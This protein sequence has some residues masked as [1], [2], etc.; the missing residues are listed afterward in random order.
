MM[1][2]LVAFSLPNVKTQPH[3]LP[4]E[5]H[6]GPCGQLPHD[7]Y[8]R[9]RGP[10]ALCWRSRIGLRPGMVRLACDNTR[11]YC[12]PHIASSSRQQQPHWHHQPRP[13]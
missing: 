12:L 10:P 3:S 9:C 11:L 13:Q 4:V 8:P 2:V 1:R 7:L 6:A 5:I